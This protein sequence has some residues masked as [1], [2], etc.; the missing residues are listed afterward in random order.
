MTKKQEKS[1]FYY[2]ARTYMVLH[3]QD[4]CGKRKGTK[5]SCKYPVSRDGQSSAVAKIRACL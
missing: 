2:Y 5:Y 1:S 4:D 3:K